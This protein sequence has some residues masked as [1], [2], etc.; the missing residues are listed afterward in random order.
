M[1]QTPCLS[2]RLTVVMDLYETFAWGKKSKDAKFGLLKIQRNLP[3]V[4]D[5]KFDLM[6][7]GIF[8]CAHC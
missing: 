5:V 2:A 7:C 8:R 3:G 6:F 1:L 4:D